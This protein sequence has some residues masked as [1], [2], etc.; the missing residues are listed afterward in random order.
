MNRMHFLSGLL[1]KGSIPNCWVE[2]SI[3]KR[4]FAINGSPKAEQGKTERILVPF[5]DGVTEAGATVVKHYA[6]RLQIKSCT[7]DFSCWSLTPGKC[8]RRDDMQALYEELRLSDILVLAT[9]VYTPL[10]GNFQN[11]MNRLCPIIEPRLSFR[12]GRTRAAFQA[13]VRIRK[14]VLVSCC[15]WWELGNFGTVQ[16]IVKDFAASVS[17]TFAG[18]LLR[19]HAEELDAFP[20]ESAEIYQASKRAGYELITAGR[21][22][23]STLKIISQELMPEEVRRQESNEAYQRHLDNTS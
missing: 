20:E 19:P 3:T 13:D 21:M 1:R 22:K 23:R 9:P 16:R 7:G 8:H 10:P 14:I 6:E 18:A 15:G 11:F 17:V 5:L 4:V 12:N 2:V